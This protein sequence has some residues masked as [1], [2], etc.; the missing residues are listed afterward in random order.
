MFLKNC[1]MLDQHEFMK[2]EVSGAPGRRFGIWIELIGL[3]CEEAEYLT[4]RSHTEDQDRLLV[5]ERMELS[6]IAAIGG[7]MSA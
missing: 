4:F 2:R 1:D 6:V 3:A 5:I 7:S